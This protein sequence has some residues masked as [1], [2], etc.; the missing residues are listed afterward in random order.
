MSHDSKLRAS[1]NGPDGINSPASR[2]DSRARHKRT[3]SRRLRRAWR[4]REIGD[5]L[6]DFEDSD[7]PGYAAFAEGE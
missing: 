5:Y 1:H 4:A 3:T 2:D 6:A 7:E